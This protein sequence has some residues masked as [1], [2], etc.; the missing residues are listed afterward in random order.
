LNNLEELQNTYRNMNNDQLLQLAN[1][2]LSHLRP[3][4]LIIFKEELKNRNLSFQKV[5][6]DHETQ[7]NE[8][9]QLNINQLPPHIIT[10]LFNALEKN[11][12]KQ[13]IL[14]GMA[15]R[16]FEENETTSL[17]SLIPEFVEPRIKK[18]KSILLSGFTL[19]ISGIAIN[20][21]PLSSNQMAIVIIAYSL[22]AVG[23]LRMFHG[24][25]TKKRLEK[26]CS[27]C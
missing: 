12:T 25:F 4:A 2:E 3:E 5:S 6:D 15:E 26:I 19:F 24:Y 14:E 22:T 18:M 17:I 13:E 16:G 11:N 9:I 8:E 21:L 10:Y 23:I 20:S 27:H 1:Q 7:S